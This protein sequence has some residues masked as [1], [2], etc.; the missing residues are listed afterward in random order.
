LNLKDFTLAK[1]AALNE[2]LKK[3]WIS[4]NL[5][6]THPWKA[7]TIEKKI[8]TGSNSLPTSIEEKETL[9]GSA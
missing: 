8:Y 3:G 1:T 6:R 5:E 9:A 2:I 7:G 4:K